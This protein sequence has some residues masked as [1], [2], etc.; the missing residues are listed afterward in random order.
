MTRP[1]LLDS[2]SQKSCPMFKHISETFSFLCPVILVNFY[3][4]AEPR[5]ERNAKLSGLEN[6]T[7]I[8]LLLP[9]EVSGVV[10]DTLQSVA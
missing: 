8:F 7:L 10:S 9:I 3:N 6:T 5:S 2:M 4:I 1:Q